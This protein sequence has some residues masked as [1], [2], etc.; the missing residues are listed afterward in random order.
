MTHSDILKELNTTLAGEYLTWKQ[1]RPHLQW[2]LDKLNDDLD[3]VFPDLGDTL[4]YTYPDDEDGTTHTGY[5]YIP[6]KYIR[7]VLINGAAHH[8]YMVDDE[9][10]TSE[11][12]FAQEMREGLF[13]AL[14]DYSAYIPNKYFKDADLAGSMAFSIEDKVGRRGIWL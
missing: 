2:A 9:G 4:E 3:T 13:K 14:R 1:A 7:A 10:M 6:D 8:F 5:D 11:V 12:T